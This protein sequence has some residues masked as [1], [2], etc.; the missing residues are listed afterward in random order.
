MCFNDLA[1]KEEKDKAFNDR[2]KMDYNDIPINLVVN[3]SC[4]HM[5]NSWYE[6][7]PMGKVVVLHTNDYFSNPQHMNCCEDVEAAKVKYPMSEI[8]YEGAL[9][10]QLYNRF[11]LI[12]KK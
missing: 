8:Y 5:D 3:T 9:D 2:D 12:G 6:N 11:M 1:P 7:L 4:E 10:T